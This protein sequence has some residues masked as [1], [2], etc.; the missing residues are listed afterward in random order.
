MISW[1]S[2]ARNTKKC[3][4]LLFFQEDYFVPREGDKHN[5]SGKIYN[6][7]A[8]LKQKKRQRDKSEEAFLA[9]QPRSNVDEPQTSP[10]T[11]VSEAIGWLQL[12]SRPWD[13]VQDKWKKT[14][15]IR[16]DILR[17]ANQE[18]TLLKKFWHFKDPLGY[19]LVIIQRLVFFFI[20]A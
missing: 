3:Y 5:H 15:V 20:I 2:S 14:F 13:L 9:K 12:N 16:K 17:K 6:K 19:Q 8:N 4:E 1:V 11:D 10:Q 7:I 18:S